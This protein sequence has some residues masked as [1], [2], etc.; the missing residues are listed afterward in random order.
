VTRD[1]HPALARYIVV[2]IGA[3]TEYNTQEWRKID[4]ILGSRINPLGVG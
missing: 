2:Q 3:F 1:Q 4:A